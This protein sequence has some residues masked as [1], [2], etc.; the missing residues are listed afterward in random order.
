MVIL[1]FAILGGFANRVRGGLFADP[2]RSFL[3]GVH[4]WLENAWR[5]VGDRL[6]TVGLVWGLIIGIGT[7]SVWA[8]ILGGLLGYVGS[9]WGWAQWQDMGTMHG[10]LSGDL[11]GM[12]GRGA[13][14][15]V[16]L[17]AAAAV[18]GDWYL[19]FMISLASFG[20]PLGY[21]VARLLDDLQDPSDRPAWLREVTS[22]ETLAGALMFGTAALGLAA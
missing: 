8:G 18:Y 16:P 1:F 10:S 15:C 17:S 4:P 14:W 12:L 21:G 5:S 19:S 3:R 22:N 13:M 9:I 7:G 20:L 6:L 11:L 2:I